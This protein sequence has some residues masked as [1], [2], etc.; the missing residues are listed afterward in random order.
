E[1]ISKD[2]HIRWQ[3]ILADRGWLGHCWKKSYGGTGW[4]PIERFIWEEEIRLAG[5]QRANLPA[6]DL[7]GAL[8]IEYGTE[9]AK[10]PLLPD[11]QRSEDWWCQG[12]SEPGAGSDLASLKMR[13]VRDGDHYVVNGTKLWTSYAHDSNWIFCLVRTSVEPKKQAG[14]SY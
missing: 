7:L 5:A 14:I 4:G 11:M 1:K 6:I 9:E 3:R 10:A 8:L 12:F 2:D 13:A